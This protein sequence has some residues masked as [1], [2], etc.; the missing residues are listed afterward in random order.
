MAELK[1]KANNN[2][3]SD[4]INSLADEQK[5]NDSFAICAIMEEVCNAK[6]TMWGDAIIGFGNRPYV[7]PDG[8]QMDWF[9]MGFS[10]RKQNIALYISSLT[11]PSLPQLGKYKTAKS[12]LYINTLKDVDIEVFK[13]ILRDCC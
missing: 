2:N 10:P 8:R 7:Y 12:C 5:R 3:V 6:A 9:M 4:F 13:Q 11:H 1:T